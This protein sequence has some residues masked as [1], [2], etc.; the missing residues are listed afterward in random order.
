MICINKSL[1]VSFVVDITHL[2]NVKI[3]VVFAMLIVRSVYMLTMQLHQE[4]K[5]DYKG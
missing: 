5:D 4:E 1:S 2:F 3:K